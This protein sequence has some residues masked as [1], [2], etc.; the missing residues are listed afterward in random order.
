MTH[1]SHLIRKTHDLISKSCANFLLHHLSLCNNLYK[2]P[3]YLTMCG[4]RNPMSLVRLRFQSHQSIPTHMLTIDDNQRDAYDSCA[5]TARAVV[6]L[7]CPSGV[8]GS[9]IHLILECP[10]TSHVALDLIQLL[11]TLLYDTCQPDWTTLTIHQQTSLILGDPPSTLP[12]KFHHVWLKSTF[13]T[14]LDY[15][16]C[17]QTLLYNMA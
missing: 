9:E 5:S 6:C 2:L 16:S 12:K 14:I 7:Y 4:H 3:P 11:T 1:P 10:A 15:V 13:P 8:A 17:L